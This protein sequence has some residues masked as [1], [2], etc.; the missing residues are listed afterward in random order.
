[1]IPSPQN[2]KGYEICPRCLPGV[3]NVITDMSAHVLKEIS[4]LG[5]NSKPVQDK[6][7]NNTEIS[8]FLKVLQTFLNKILTD[9]KANRNQLV[10][11]YCFELVEWLE[12]LKYQ[13]QKKG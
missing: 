3:Q 1:M 4:L 11:V 5:L 2:N 8:S 7:L 12:K 9:L 6:S 13:T 10:E